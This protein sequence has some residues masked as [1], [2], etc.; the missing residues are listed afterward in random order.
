MK[1]VI[2]LNGETNISDRLV[3]RQDVAARLGVTVYE[4]ARRE[5]AGQLRSEKRRGPHREVFYRESEIAKHLARK[6]NKE[7]RSILQDKTIDPR[8]LFSFT[9]NESQLVFRLIREKTPLEQI[10][11]EHGIHPGAIRA[12]VREYQEMTGA[13]L[14]NGDVMTEINQL[15]LDGNFPIEKSEDLLALLTEAASSDC[16][17]CHKRPKAVCKQCV[18][19]VA[20]TLDE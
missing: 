7:N 1:G 6:A 17:N 10:V 18:V 5:K 8:L 13:F 19:D 15:P 11:I 14:V 20:E 4:I 12:I 2:K 3:N 16:I 9:P